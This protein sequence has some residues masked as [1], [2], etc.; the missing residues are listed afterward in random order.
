[1]GFI[2]DVASLEPVM[3]AEAELDRDAVLRMISEGCPNGWMPGDEEED[4]GTADLPCPT[5]TDRDR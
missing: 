1:M 5:D 3:P 2:G 4:V